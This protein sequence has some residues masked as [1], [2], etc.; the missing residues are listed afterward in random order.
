MRSGGGS[1]PGPGPMS[2]R[3]RAPGDPR[4]TRAWKLLVRTVKREEPTCWLQLPGICTGTSTTG[5][6]VVPVS[7]APEL[8]L[9]RSNVRGACGPCNWRRQDTP[10]DQL[11]ELRARLERE[12]QPPAL[13]WFA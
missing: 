7:A 6:H 4:T 2:P 13:G 3:Y 9:V 11:E 12:R 8:A 10:V 5:D 1:V